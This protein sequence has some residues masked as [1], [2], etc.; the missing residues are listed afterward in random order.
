[1]DD[2]F[3]NLI[4]IIIM[5]DFCFYSILL[6]KKGSIHIFVKINNV[7][8]YVCMYVLIHKYVFIYACLY[9]L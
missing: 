4:I 8:T 3:C 7:S 1:M 6:W 9:F 5:F 2:C